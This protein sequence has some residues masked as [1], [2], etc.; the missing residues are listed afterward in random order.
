MRA[1][2]HSEIV[3]AGEPTG[4]RIYRSKQERR[5]IAEESL[6]PG[7]SVAAIARN[8]GVNANQVFQ[9]RKLL[10]EGRLDL[11]PVPTQL[12]PVRIAEVFSAERGV[13]RSSSGTILVELG[14]TRVRIEGAADPESLRL[15]L[16]HLGR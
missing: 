11:K 16:E 9:W 7:A 2:E 3:I 6:R 12:M 1:G 13:A 5:V 4:K 14:R 8:H 15:I 10:R